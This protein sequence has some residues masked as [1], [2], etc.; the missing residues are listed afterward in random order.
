[1]KPSVS[2]ENIEAIYSLS[3]TQE[4]MLFH[5][6][7]SP[8]LALYFNQYCCILHGE[9]DPPK[10][11]E[12]WEK[13]VERH[14]VLRTLFTWERRKNPLQIVRQRVTVPWEVKDWRGIPP[15]EQAKKLELFLDADRQRG[16]ELSKAP[17]IRLSLFQLTA[18]SFQFIWSFHHLI[19][20]GWSMRLVLR[21]M[22]SIYHAD[23]R[24]KDQVGTAPPCYQRYIHWLQKQDREEAEKFWRKTLEG[25]T[26]PTQIRLN[27]AIHQGEAKP[28]LVRQRQIQLSE[29]VSA[30][31]QSLARHNRLTTNTILQGAWALLLHHYSG[32]SDIVF[33]TTMSN[34]PASLDRVET[35]V[36]LFITTIPVRIKLKSDDSLMSWLK[37]IQDQQVESSQYAYSP[38]VKIQ[39]WSG[40][41]RG[42]TL[43]NSILVFENHPADVSLKDEGNN[44]IEV[45]DIQ[46]FERSNYPIALLAVPGARLQFIVVYD[47]DQYHDSVISRLLTHL[48]TVLESIVSNPHRRLSDIQVLSEE[49]H[50]RLMIE[51]N[52][53]ETNQSIE[54]CWHREFELKVPEIAD[55]VALV[56]KNQSLRYDELNKKANKIAR[57]LVECGV[58]PDTLVGIYLE[59]SMEMIIGLVAI[60]KAGGAYVPLDPMYP[61]AR[62]KWML[63]DTQVAIV[64]TKKRF[65]QAIPESAIRTVCL[66]SNFDSENRFPENNL[67][68]EVTPSN[69]AYVIY[70]S[71][72]SGVP[73]GV[74]VTHENLQH[75]TRARKNYYRQPV[76]GFLLFSTYSFDSSVAGIF[77][78]LSEGGT[79][80][81]PEDD[82]FTETPYIAQ[83]IE[84]Y[85][86][87]HMLCV[88]AFYEQLLATESDSLK[89]LTTMIVAGEACPAVLAKSHNQRLENASLFNEYGPTEATVW[90]TVYKYDGKINSATLPIGRPLSDTKIY[91]LNPDLKLTPIGVPGELF[92]GGRGLAKGYLN[93]PTLTEARFISNPFINNPED[94]LYKTGDIVRFLEDGNLEFLGRNDD[95]VKVRGYRIE[96]DEIMNTLKQHPGV[97]QAIVLAE[98]EDDTN[99]KVDEPRRNQGNDFQ[100]LD[101]IVQVIDRDTL[102]NMISGVEN[103]PD[104]ESSITSFLESDKPTESSQPIP[105]TAIEP[106]NPI[107]YLKKTSYNDFEVQFTFKNENFINPPRKTQREWLV[108]Q[109]LNE[110]SD[111]LIDLDR[112][113]KEFVPG[114]DMMN[115]GYI[116]DASHSELPEQVILEDWQIPIMKSM[117]KHATET[118]GDILEIGFGRGVSATFIQEHGVRSHTIVECNSFSIKNYYEPWKQRYPQ[119]DIKLIPER[120]EDVEKELGLFDGIFFHAFPLDDEEFIRYVVNSI[121]FAEHFFAVAARHLR[122]KGAFTYLTTEINSLSR[123]HQ[124]ALFKHFTSINLSLEPLTIPEDTKDAWWADTMVIVKAVK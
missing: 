55:Q 82:R 35:M 62:L 108:T 84:R 112:V 117:A 28:S 3:P 107:K 119:N 15:Q 69:L 83:L 24:T 76:K 40:I 56:Y 61:Q 93:Q 65:I 6:L 89:S 34:R 5:T 111:D 122:K 27:G 18:S 75:S 78:T 9:L 103:L 7:Y 57:H 88:P 100:H 37:Q 39:S 52:G 87:T 17:L 66:D 85:Q 16:F 101:E 20:D 23:G 109:L 113:S 11:R 79:L 106:D 26:Y 2:K 91:V 50:E 81:I 99:P 41:P 43:F 60:L 74:M 31:L 90:S 94:R 124:R 47:A 46:Y 13:V 72:S 36:G 96:L 115:R 12:A 77:W 10:L 110:V 29:S 80:Y 118:G 32:D 116:S 59:R 67:E 121:T 51:W 70:T 25:F 19:L 49:E 53:N 64:I 92:I 123:R 45:K 30:D 22:F 1:M 54:Q 48:K 33:G 4:G 68:I 71:G 120:W 102:E 42:H 14:P 86:V 73:K 97:A 8:E 105:D 104:S 58:T 21:E 98:D 38:L 114:A 95:Q 63:E 44:R